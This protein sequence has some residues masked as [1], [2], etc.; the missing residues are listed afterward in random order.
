MIHTQRDTAEQHDWGDGL[1]MT[2]L[3]PSNMFQSEMTVRSYFNFNFQNENNS[4]FSGIETPPSPSHL[5][6]VRAAERNNVIKATTWCWY[7]FPCIPYQLRTIFSQLSEVP[8]F[9]S[10][11]NWIFMLCTAGGYRS[12]VFDSK[13]L[14]SR[15]N[16]S[17]GVMKPIVWAGTGYPYWAIM[18]VKWWN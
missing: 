11:L 6:P 17:Q 2:L 3:I 12:V 10:E 8:S 18:C 1:K 5:Y 7:Q 9:P 15:A 13:F 4:I 16:S 14:L